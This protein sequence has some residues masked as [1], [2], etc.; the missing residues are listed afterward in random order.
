MFWRTTEMSRT[1]RNRKRLRAQR[2][3]ALVIALALTLCLTM[4]VVASSLQV[5]AQ[6]QSERGQRNSERA[7][8]LA[9]AGAN[10]YLNYL[11]TGINTNLTPWDS[12]HQAPLIPT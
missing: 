6:L 7:L 12:T 10:A 4:L 8:E 1:S 3:A 5:V 2:G 11:A 9:E